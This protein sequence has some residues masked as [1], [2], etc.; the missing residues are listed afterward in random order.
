MTAAKEKPQK[1]KDRV[2]LYWFL[3]FF[4]TFMILDGIFVYL[5]VSTQTGL[6]TEKAYEKGLAYNQT[7]EEA[8]NQPDIID[9]VSYENGILQWVLIDKQNQALKAVTKATFFRPVQA[10]YDFTVP[11]EQKDAG[12][13]EI[14]PDLPLKGLWSVR[15]EA[16]WDNKTYK[17][18]VELVSR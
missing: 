1:N 17:T 9:E 15:L 6:V 12:V 11:L 7:L 16:Q 8:K 4:G 2:I 18:T 3:A 10:G 14:K 13:Y 5:A